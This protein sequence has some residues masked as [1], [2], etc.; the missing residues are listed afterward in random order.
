MH[1][2]AYRWHNALLTFLKW[3]QPIPLRWVGPLGPVI[4]GIAGLHLGLTPSAFNSR[5]ALSLRPYPICHAHFE[6]T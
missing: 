4:P 2:T 6:I 5:N 3:N 1:P